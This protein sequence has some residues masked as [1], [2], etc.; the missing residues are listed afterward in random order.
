MIEEVDEL[1]PENRFHVRSLAA[2]HISPRDPGELAAELELELE[3]VAG[4]C[5]RGSGP[6]PGGFEP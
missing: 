3:L 4:L 5:H 6:P 1:T 2:P